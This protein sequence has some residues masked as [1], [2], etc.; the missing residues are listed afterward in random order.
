MEYTFI[1]ALCLTL[2]FAS[3]VH[4]AIGFGF[5]MISTPIIALF[6][7]MQ[8]TILYML[9]PT[10]GAN[11]LSILSEGKFLEALKKFW[12]IITL[13]VIGSALGTVLLLYTNSDL[14]KL[15]LA[16]I[17][18]LYLLQSVVKIEATFVSK[19]PRSSTY[20]LGIFGGM[21]SGLTNIVA[22][23]MIMYTLELKY[24]RKDTVQLSN[25]CFLFTKIGQITVFL[26][27]GSFT[28]EDFNISM[29][30]LAATFIGMFLGI[31]VKKLIDAKLYVKIL[32]VLLFII[33]SMLV[34]QTISF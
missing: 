34:V 27:H 4:G 22:P 26:L 8:T 16:G 13:M 30:G 5:G 19:Y 32:K 25:L 3:T 23:L 18:F 7:D 28:V 31:K 6:T 9:I 17:I 20:G 10:M 12:F 11:I 1:L 2:F 14:F 24:S 15:L 29:I 33:A 21:L